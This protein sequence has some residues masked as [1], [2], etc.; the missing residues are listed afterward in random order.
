[1][2][3]SSYSEKQGEQFHQDGK[4]MEKRYQV[5]YAEKMMGDYI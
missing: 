5:H 3:K 4:D 2:I 1:M